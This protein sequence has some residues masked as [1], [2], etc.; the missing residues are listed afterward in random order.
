MSESKRKRPKSYYKKCAGGGK[1][2]KAVNDLDAGMKGFLVTCNKYERETVREMYNI[3]NE[4]A[5]TLYGPETAT[6]EKTDDSDD[7]GEEEEEDIEKALEKER[8]DILKLAKTERRFQNT[9]TKFKNLI[10]IRT[11]LE[12]PCGLAHHIFTDMMAT[13]TQKARYAQRMIPVDLTCKANMKNIEPAMKIVL[14]PHFQTAFGV[15]LRYTSVCKIRNNNSIQRIAILPM[16]GRLVNEM[17]PLHRLCHDDSELVVIVEVIRNICCLSV[18]K[19]FFTF[20]KYNFHE[21]I[22][23]GKSETEGNRDQSKSGKEKSEVMKENSV[24]E[25]N[26]PDDGDGREDISDEKP[27]S[28]HKIEDTA[29]SNLVDVNDK[30][31]DPESQPDV[32]G[33]DCKDVENDR[34]AIEQQLLDGNSNPAVVT[35]ESADADVS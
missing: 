11:A 21:V 34:P 10:F 19:D 15:G 18:V 29:I 9:N 14:T 7:S 13:H 17:N 5:D 6:S 30:T 12:D 26:V 3:L 33:I 28:E 22:K 1:K 4:Y 20:R 16:I 25:L 35:T 27:E 32:V 23:T 2:F 31:G 24:D 8:S